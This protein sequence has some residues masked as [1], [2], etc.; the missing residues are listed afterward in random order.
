MLAQAIEAEVEAFLTSHEHL[1]DKEGRRQVIRNGYLP[2]RT[3]QSGIGDIAIKAPRVRDRSGSGIRFTSAILPPYLRRTKSIEELIPWLYSEGDF[4][5]GILRGSGA[6]GG[7][8][9]P[10]RRSRRYQGTEVPI[11][12]QRRRREALAAERHRP[13]SGRHH[14]QPDMARWWQ[15]VCRY[16]QG[17]FPESESKDVSRCA[18]GHLFRIGSP[19]PLGRG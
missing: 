3:I 14:P 2:E 11:N 19:G 4:H 18:A 16:P 17:S 13:R 9:L 7:N 8:C 6:P 12:G 5:G 1:R 15:D 10:C